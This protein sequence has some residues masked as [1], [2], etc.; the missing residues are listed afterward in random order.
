VCQIAGDAQVDVTAGEPGPSIAVISQDEP[1][2]QI[3][4]SLDANF[5][6]LGYP[7]MRAFGS[8]YVAHFL[9]RFRLISVVSIC[10]SHSH[11]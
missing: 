7:D 10:A 9:A 8:H 3:H 1:G 5:P 11:I 4:G 6:A 2:F